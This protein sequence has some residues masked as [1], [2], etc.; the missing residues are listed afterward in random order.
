MVNA[1]LLPANRRIN[2]LMK[3]VN[4]LWFSCLIILVHKK[5]QIEF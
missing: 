1:Q 4:H 2:K 5:A 3:I